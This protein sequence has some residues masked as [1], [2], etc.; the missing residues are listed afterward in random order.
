MT[1]MASNKFLLI[2]RFVAFIAY[3]Y[4]VYYI[5]T[6]ETLPPEVRGRPFGKWKYLTYWDLL[7]QLGFFGLALIGSFRWTPKSFGRLLDFLFYSL[8]FPI[9]MIVTIS[10]W[11]LYSIDRELV[12]P[13]ALDAYYPFWLNQTSH[14]LVAFLVLI[15]L[16]FGNRNPPSKQAHGLIIINLF[17]YVYSFWV[18]YIAFTTNFW[19]YPFLEKLNWPLRISFGVALGLVNSLFYKM[20]ILCGRNLVKQTPNRKNKKIK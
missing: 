10:F 11:T 12:F 16:I 7:L 9:A 2:V 14:T 1:K 15:E 13:K 8:V 20:A 3:G 19:V 5:W 4:S 18:L 17:S 6:Y